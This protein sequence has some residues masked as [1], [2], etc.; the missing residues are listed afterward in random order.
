[1]NYKLLTQFSQNSLYVFSQLEELA[2]GMEIPTPVLSKNFTISTKITLSNSIITFDFKCS[3]LD[4]RTGCNA[5]TFK[6]ESISKH[7]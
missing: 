2:I 6:L 1:M 7:L 4:E 3:E 5:H